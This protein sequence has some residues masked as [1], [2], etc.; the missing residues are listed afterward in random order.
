LTATDLQIYVEVLDN[1][2]I[3]VTG[4]LV[5][6]RGCTWASQVSSRDNDILASGKKLSRER[7][8]RRLSTGNKYGWLE[9]CCHLEGCKS[10]VI[11]EGCAFLG[12]NV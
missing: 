4:A 8:R 7:E 6:L 2:G 10:A 3:D 11:W 12:R 1:A 5:V 9:V